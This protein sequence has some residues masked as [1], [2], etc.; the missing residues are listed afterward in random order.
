MQEEIKELNP[1]AYKPVGKLLKSL[2]IPAIIA[3]IAKD[4]NSLDIFLYPSGLA[5]LI[6]SSI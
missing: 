4:L 6:S 3:G 1:L 2:A 5:V